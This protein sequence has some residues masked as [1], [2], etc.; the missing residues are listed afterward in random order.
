MYVCFVTG[1]GKRR[2]R[3]NAKKNFERKKYRKITVSVLLEVVSVNT[4]ESELIVNLPLSAYTSATL[5]DVTVLHSRI[6]RSNALPAGWNLACLPAS[7]SYLA[8]FALCKLKIFPP[9]CSSHATFML[10]VSP[11][12]AWTLCI[13]QSQ[14]DQQQCR[15]LGGITAKLCS[16]DEVVKL[17]LTL[18]DSKHC[19]ENPDTKF[20]QLGSLQGSVR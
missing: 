3:F 17:L 13:G 16:V 6:S 10:T 2:L 15:L 20:M 4:D 1:M 11:S 14:I 8:T 12:C 9:L 7:T 18:D 5:P 19:V